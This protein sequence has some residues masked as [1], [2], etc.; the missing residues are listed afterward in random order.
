MDNI[1]DA[2]S[3]R[4]CANKL[5]QCWVL[6]TQEYCSPYCSVAGDVAILDDAELWCECNHI[7]CVI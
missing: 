6:A 3:R 1:R 2:E 7:P 4:K 5:C